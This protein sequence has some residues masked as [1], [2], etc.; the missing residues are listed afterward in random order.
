MRAWEVYLAG[1]AFPEPN[2]RPLY[3]QLDGRP[4]L[5][6]DDVASSQGEEDEEKIVH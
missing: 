1:G 5:L 6:A 2:M 4:T 3:R